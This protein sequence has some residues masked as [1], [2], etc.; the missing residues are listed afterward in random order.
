MVKKALSPA[1][2]TSI[3]YVT[4]TR[5]ALHL[6]GTTRVRDVDQFH[7]ALQV[8]APRDHLNAHAGRVGTIVAEAGDLFDD[9]ACRERLALS[10]RGDG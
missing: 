3:R 5:G 9:A 1:S 6:S 10:G 4:V 2:H 7:G 8:E